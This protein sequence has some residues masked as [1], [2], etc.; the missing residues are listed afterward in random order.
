MLPLAHGAL[1]NG[2]EKKAGPRIARTAALGAGDVFWL[3]LIAAL[4]ICWAMSPS[5]HQSL[6]LTGD[7][8]GCA[9]AGKAGVVCSASAT[10]RVISESNSCVS[11]GKAGRYCSAPTK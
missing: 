10:Q 4:F 3:A 7:S 11:L 9:F 6:D 1:T 5:A 2:A 8:P